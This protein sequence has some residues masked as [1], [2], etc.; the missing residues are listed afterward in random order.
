LHLG[1]SIVD[2][3]AGSFVED[4]NA[5]DLHAGSCTDLVGSGECDVERKDLI[6]E[7]GE[8]FLFEAGDFI[9]TLTAE[10]VDRGYALARRLVCSKLLDIS[11]E[12]RRLYLPCESYGPLRR[13][14]L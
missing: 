9:V 2:A 10:L 4:L 13:V 6:G 5:E 7:G 1:H 3:D 8:C 11:T 12:Y 14:L